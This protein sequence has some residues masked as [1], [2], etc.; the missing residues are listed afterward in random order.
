MALVIRLL[1]LLGAASWSAALFAPLVLAIARDR[2]QPRPEQIFLTFVLLSVV[3]FESA[4]RGTDRTRWL[5]P[6]QVLWANLQGSWVFGPVIAWI[7]AA[8]AWLDARTRR[9]DGDAATEEPSGA[10]RRAPRVAL[11]AALGLVLWAASAIVPRPLETLAHP[12]HLLQEASVDP[13][14]GS[15][16]E[17]R[18]WNWGQDRGDPF[19]VLLALWLIALLVGGQRLL[20][21]SPA[22]VTIALGTF[23][24]GY[25]GVRFRGLAAWM[26][27]APL[28][29]AFAPRGPRLARW[30]LAVP[31]LAAAALGGYWLVTAPQYTFGIDPQLYSVPVRAAALAESL[32]LEGP[33]LNTFHHGG[34]LLWARGEKNP[35]LIDGRSG[36]GSL[37]FRSMYARALYD[38]VA[39]DSLL[40]A[41]DFDYLLIEPPQSTSDR[42]PIN[43]ARRLEWALIFYDDAGLLY[44]RWNRHPELAA[45][46]AYRYFSPDYLEMLTL[47]EH[48]MTDAGLGRLLEAEL[49]RARAQSPFHSRASLWLGLQALGRSDGKTAVRYLDEA[50]R[51][52]PAMPGLALRQ[53]MAHEMAGDPKG[54]LKAYRRALREEEDRGMAAASIQTLQSRH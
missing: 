22:L 3:L 19:T 13:L 40:E 43:I 6:I 45:A 28:A 30:G 48:T 24:L 7:Y 1:F 34:Y 15:I 8:T 54:A 23:V 36:R 47:S 11:W 5:I 41:W 38:P 16:Q 33:M 49:M 46:R 25:L 32:H 31:G 42:M 2:F 35:P 17:L 10:P 29:V 44:V 53:G 4:R 18:G 37:A 39:L 21:A 12:F 9:A 51:I 20:R 50:E 52:A 14:T 26:S 27:Y